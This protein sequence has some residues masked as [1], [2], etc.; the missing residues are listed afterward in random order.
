MVL[1]YICNRVELE[2][3]CDNTVF[4]IWYSMGDV[5]PEENWV[6]GILRL[7]R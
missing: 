4:G 6:S 1:V 3:K 7:R 2:G 5:D